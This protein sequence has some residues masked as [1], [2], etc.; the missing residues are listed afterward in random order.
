[1][2]TP[3]KKGNSLPNQWYTFSKK[4]KNNKKHVLEEEKINAPVSNNVQ[5]LVI[6]LAA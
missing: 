4:I 3:T 1:M 6:Y 5:N 2:N